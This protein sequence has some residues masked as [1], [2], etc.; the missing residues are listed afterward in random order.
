M[1]NALWYKLLGYKLLGYKLL[2]LAA[3]LIAFGW[4]KAADA[5]KRNM[6]YYGSIAASAALMRTGPGRNFPAKWRYQRAGLPVKI[7]DTYKDWRKVEDP[8]GEQGWMLGNLLSNK[9]AGIVTGRVVDMLKE[10]HYGARVV[11]RAG[12]GVVGRLSRCGHGWCLFDVRGR[13]GYI[14]A[15]RV[16]GSGAEATTLNAI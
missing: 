11:W 5:Q 16:W 7:I 1:Q 2:L 4:A 9:A 8:D 10:P 12:R 14:E 6:P 13:T 3:A 15:N